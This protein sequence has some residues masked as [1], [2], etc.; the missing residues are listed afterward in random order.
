MPPDAAPIGE[1]IAFDGHPGEPL[2]PNQVSKKKVWEAVQPQLG[3]SADRVA[4]YAGLP[5]TTQSGP[6]TVATI[7]GGT[8]K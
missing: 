1:R 4:T 2:P 8:I 6:C 5:F 7:G 3:T